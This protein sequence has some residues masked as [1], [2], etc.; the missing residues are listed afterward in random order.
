MRKA[1]ID[2]KLD[3]YNQESFLASSMFSDNTLRALDNDVCAT[4][5]PHAVA[6]N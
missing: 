2:P 4:N 3:L 6:A 5:G 1:L